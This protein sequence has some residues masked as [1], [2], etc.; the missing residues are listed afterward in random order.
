[1]IENILNKDLNNVTRRL[2]MTDNVESCV[3]INQSVNQSVNQNPSHRPVN[4][5]INQSINFLRSFRQRKKDCIGF[6]LSTNGM[7]MQ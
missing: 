2:D 7:H 1:M 4:K 6:Y 3:K 5:S